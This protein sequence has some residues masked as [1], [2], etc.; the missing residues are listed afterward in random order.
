MTL[1]WLPEWCIPDDPNSPHAGLGIVRSGCTGLHRFRVRSYSGSCACRIP[2]EISPSH[3]LDVGVTAY[4]RDSHTGAAL[5]GLTRATLDAPG[6]ASRYSR[7][8]WPTHSDTEEQALYPYREPH[9]ASNTRKYPR[10]PS[11]RPRP[12]TA[13]RGYSFWCYGSCCWCWWSSSGSGVSGA[14]YFN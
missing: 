9:T 11:S 10:F 1:S 2:A 8:D 5:G 13:C 12:D 14:A 6:L 3:D 4:L 7:W